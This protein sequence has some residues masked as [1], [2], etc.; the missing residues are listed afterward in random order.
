MENDNKMNEQEKNKNTTTINEP[1]GEVTG[2]MSPEEKK[3][4]KR[5][6]IFAAI[7]GVL[8]VVILGLCVG[9]GIKDGWF[10]GNVIS[11]SSSDGTSSNG[12]NIAAGGTYEITGENQCITV[13]TTSDVKLILNNATINCDNGPAIYIAEAGD[14]EIVLKGEN[15]ISATTSDDLEGVIHSKEDLVISGD[16]S[17][18]LTGNLDGIVSKDTLTIKGGNYVVKTG[19]DCIKGKD[20]VVITGGTFNL[21]STAG[22]GIKSSNDEDVALGYVKITGGEIT[23]NVVQDGIQAKTNV[24]IDSGKITI[25]SGDDGIHANGKL[26]INGGVITIN[27]HEGLEATYILINDGEIDITA[28]DDGMNAG[29]KSNLY[30]VAIEINGGSIKIDMGAGDTDAIDSN[31]N[32]KITGGTIDII[33]QSPFDYDGTLTY[34]G[35]TIIVNGETVNS[36]TNQFMGGDMGGAGGMGRP[37]GF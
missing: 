29:S 31:G 17:L 13:D 1:A 20:N 30:T 34:T 23:I 21:T 36:V 11:G 28:S 10:S 19:D 5:Q 15:T 35:G 27:A 37:G 4:K 8:V 9:F 22:D 16:G 14:V 2:E 25:N 18:T 26:E 24:T 6:T 3:L 7:I 12:Q 32:L 33:A